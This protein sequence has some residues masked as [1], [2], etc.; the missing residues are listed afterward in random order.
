MS[1]SVYVLR[2]KPGLKD[3]VPLALDSNELIIGWTDVP[4]LLDPSLSL[5]DFRSLLSAMYY[6]EAPTLGK[7]ASAAGNMWRFLREMSVGD[8]V[9]V[10]HHGEFYVA[11][12]VGDATHDASLQEGGFRR[13][14]RWLNDKNPF[15]RRD[16]P[17]VYQAL[18]ERK[19]CYRIDLKNRPDVADLVAQLYAEP[20]LATDLARLMEREDIGATTRKALVD[21]RVGQGKFREDLLRI[22][23]YACAVTG[24]TERKAIRASHAK[25]WADSMDV[26]RLDPNNGLPLIGSLDALFDAGLIAFDEFG[27]MLVSN[28]LSTSNCLILAIPANLRS[29]PTREQGKFLRHHRERFFPEKE[30]SKKKGSE[31]TSPDSVGA[32]FAGTPL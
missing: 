24:C 20:E 2:I 23:G 8:F 5:R 9:L 15:L 1:A 6:P 4:E 18:L 30:L 16:Y 14:A 21:A 13:P 7:A 28:A 10:P 27:T 32:E 22:W 26:E 11:E 29:A 12:V 19:T 3:M 17:R 31:S 25:R